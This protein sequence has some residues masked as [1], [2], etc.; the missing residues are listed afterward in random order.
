MIIKTISQRAKSASDSQQVTWI[1]EVSL[2]A[3]AEAPV[4]AAAIERNMRGAFVEYPK[5]AS[6]WDLIRYFSKSADT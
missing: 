3:A 6:H 2:C 1:E 4:T 5:E